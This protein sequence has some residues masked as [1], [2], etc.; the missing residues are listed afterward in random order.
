MAT[1]FIP[2]THSYVLSIFQRLIDKDELVWA[3]VKWRKALSVLSALS[4][5]VLCSALGQDLLRQ[6]KVKAERPIDSCVGEV[7]SRFKAGLH[8]LTELFEVEAG[9]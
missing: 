5:K 8:L 4:R 2:R 9:V 6:P 7:D 1:N 3:A